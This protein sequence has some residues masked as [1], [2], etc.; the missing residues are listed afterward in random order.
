MSSKNVEL[1]ARGLQAQ[2]RSTLVWASSIVL[3]A[4]SVVAV[5]PSLERSGSLGGLTAG[6]SPQLVAA[7]GLEQFN[8]ANGYLRGNLYAVMLPLLLGSMAITAA[9]ALT[10]GDEEAGRFELLLALPLRRTQV[11]LM[12][13]VTV[14]VSLAVTSAAVAVTV[15]GSVAVL[16]MDVALDGVV[17]VAVATWL[18]AVLHAA[19]AY[20][21]AAAGCR[22]PVTL[23]VAAGVLVVGYML[24]AIAP[25]SES[26]KPLS[27]L[28][29]WDWALGDDPLKNG[30]AGGGLLLLV[31]VS[32][33]LVAAGTLL[34]DRRD[35]RTV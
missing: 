26:L 13:L 27:A 5:W 33:V 31:A 20:A 17:A 18:L 19:L 28:S 15:V 3:L 12:R 11:Y 4:V 23:G 16:D 1:L 10:S 14:V 30:F 34:I 8:T 35:I 29:P 2:R 22:P 21:A 24:Q 7:F 32:G 25:L 9:T 6:M